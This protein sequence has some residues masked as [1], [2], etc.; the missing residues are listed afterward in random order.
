MDKQEKPEELASDETTERYA[1]NPPVTCSKDEHSF[2]QTAGSEATCTKCPTG[3]N[4]GAGC[5]VKNGHIYIVGQLL[6]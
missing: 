3:Y 6:I 4:L 2:V 5:E 1:V